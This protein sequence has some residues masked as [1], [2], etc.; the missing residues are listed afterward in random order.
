MPR[1]GVRLG[2]GDKPTWRHG[3]TKTI[4][5]PIALADEILKFARNLD[6]K[7]ITEYVT[8]SKVLDLSGISIRQ[9]QG[10][11]SVYLEDLAKAGFDLRPFTLA[12]MVRA[13]LARSQEE[14]GKLRH[15][16]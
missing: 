16:R 3:K 14:K 1:G 11:A 9:Y 6:E 4:R 12:E 7:G 10:A 8:E 15:G 5:V 2:A 13:R